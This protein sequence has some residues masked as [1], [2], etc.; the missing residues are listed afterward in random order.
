LSVDSDPEAKAQVEFRARQPHN[1][2]DWFHECLVLSWTVN[3]VGNDP[4]KRI[5]YEVSTS[6]GVLGQQKYSVLVDGT[7]F[8][9]SCSADPHFRPFGIKGFKESPCVHVGAVRLF[10]ARQRYLHLK[11]LSAKGQWSNRP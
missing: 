1:S 5:K 8:W 11:E 6:I 3:F 7:W 10:Q 9:C 2:P 4:H